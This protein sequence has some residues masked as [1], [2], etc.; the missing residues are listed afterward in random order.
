MLLAGDGHRVSAVETAQQALKAV[1]GDPPDLALVDIGLP[2][3]DGYELARQLRAT[4][5][6]R[7]IRLVALTG[8]G[9]PED[10]RRARDAGFDAHLVKPVDPDQL[11]RLLDDTA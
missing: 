1:R 3:M 8:Y 10:R 4:A 11:T 6:G 9:R 5:E 7:Q 2:G